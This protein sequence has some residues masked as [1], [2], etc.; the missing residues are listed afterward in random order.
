MLFER[1]GDDHG[2]RTA[3]RPYEAAWLSSGEC[4]VLVPAA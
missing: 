3:V 4:S 2:V 1:I